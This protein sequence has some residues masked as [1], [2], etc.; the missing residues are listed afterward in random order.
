MSTFA[1]LVKCKAG[2]ISFDTGI[3]KYLPNTAK[4]SYYSNGLLLSSPIFQ[5]NK[6]NEKILF[7]VPLILFK[8]GYCCSRNCP[9]RNIKLFPEKQS[10]I[11]EKSKEI[12]EK[13]AK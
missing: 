5:K 2:A 10:K 7:F 4:E 12:P 9:A 6:K 3:R 11:K 8:L 1:Q 13:K